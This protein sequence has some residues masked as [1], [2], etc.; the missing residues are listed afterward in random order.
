MDKTMT[1]TLGLVTEGALYWQ[2]IAGKQMRELSIARAEIARLKAERGDY[3][4]ALEQIR[5][6]PLVRETPTQRYTRCVE[7]A[8][9]VLA[10]R[11][12][13]HVEQEAQGNE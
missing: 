3:L 1:D 11:Q 6:A 12:P 13:G 5:S 10:A 2:T 9:A 7:V 8:N 4:L